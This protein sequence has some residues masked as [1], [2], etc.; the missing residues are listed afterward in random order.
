MAEWQFWMLMFGVWFNILFM[1]NSF[2]AAN[3]GIKVSKWWS[4]TPVLF[5][6]YTVIMFIDTIFG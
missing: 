2:T 3:W 4:L 5:L 1:V 6:V